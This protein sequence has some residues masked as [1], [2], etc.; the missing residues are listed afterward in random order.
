MHP[1]IICLDCDRG[2]SLFYY[3]LLQSM[4]PPTHTLYLFLSSLNFAVIDHLYCNDQ[5]IPGETWIMTAI[6][7]DP[8]HWV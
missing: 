7:M 3:L 5:P 2:A 8:I 4:H 1:L 6:A